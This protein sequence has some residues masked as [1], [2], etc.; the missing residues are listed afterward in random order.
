MLPIQRLLTLSLILSGL[1]MG[2]LHASP[3][4]DPNETLKAIS[5]GFSRVAKKAIPAVV[6]IESQVTK[7]K[8]ALKKTDPKGSDNPFDYFHEEFFN[9]FFGFPDES[10]KKPE[11][12]RGS[13]FMVTSDGYILTNNHVVENAKKVTVTLQDGSK[14]PATVVGTDPKTDLAVIKISEKN[15]PILTFGNSD[16]LEVGD[17]TIAVGN[18]FGLNASVT[19]GVVS[20]KGRNQLHITDFEDFIQTDAAINPG[21]SGGPLL[22]VDGEVIGINT[23]IVSG[24]GGYMGIGFAIPSNMAVRIMDQLIKQGSVKRGFLGVTLQP[25]DTDLAQFYKLDK[26]HGALITEI[27]KGSPA[28]EAGLKQE[29]VILSYNAIAI[30]NNLS[31]F[32]NAVSFMTPGSKLHL[33]IVRDGK[34]KEIVVTISLVPD[35]KVVATAPLGK[36]GFQVQNLTPELSEQF[37]YANEK[38]VVVSTVKPGSP[39]SEAQIRPGSL[40]VAVN[41]QKVTSLNEFNAAIQESSKEGTVLLMV[42]Q[43]ETY[44]FIALKFD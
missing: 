39:A 38:G 6:Y 4:I 34:I 1:N 21:N 40:I 33:K 16:R 9:R 14:L 35:D 25:I 26:P 42:R 36:L 18:P 44:R 5:K 37:G 28:D 8:S 13:G 11:T 12:V 3:E 29:D 2:F 19:V 15:L 31:S 41:R 7:E 10:E 20:A 27:A 24:S 30:E 23:A 43:G 17:W 32:R 22:D